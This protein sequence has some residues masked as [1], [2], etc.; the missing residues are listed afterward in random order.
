MLARAD[1]V[2]MAAER[3]IEAA[4]HFSVG[5]GRTVLAHQYVPYPFHIT[6]AFHLDP[7]R[8][9]LAT[10]YLQSASGGLYRGDRLRIE[11]D[12]A[13]GAAAHVTT[14]AATVVHDT[15]GRAAAQSTRLRVARGA[16][17]AVTPDPL[18]LFPGAAIQS[19]IDVTLARGA[20]AI[21]ADGFACHDPTGKGRSFAR[22]TLATV[23]RDDE[24]RVRVSDRG[25]V[26][27]SMFLGAASPAGPCSA[28]GTLLALGPG[29][30]RIDA[31]ALERRL[32][33]VRC[34]AGVTCTP[35]ELGVAVRILA[36]DGGAL[37]L[38]LDVAFATAFEALLG[39]P[40]ARR[41]K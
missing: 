24:G 21:L 26:D 34:I 11:I 19:A 33:A 7:Q 3:R 10:L 4:L 5:G 27:G 32:D 38:G 36:P 31:A 14:Q 39:F 12:V 40:P 35:Y 6:R 37:A 15:R 16:F 20:C 41:R 17:A 18:V 13:A 2:P 1:P 30:Q 28:A 22:A 29:S 25:A 23:V 8:D 9:D